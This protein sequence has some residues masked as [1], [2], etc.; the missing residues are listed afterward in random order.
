MKRTQGLRGPPHSQ[1]V[2]LGMSPF[3]RGTRGNPFRRQQKEGLLEISV[4][5]PPARREAEEAASALRT[6]WKG[7]TDSRKT[8]RPGAGQA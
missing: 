8:L 3:L 2:E 4:H 6:G 7:W 5:P 1:G